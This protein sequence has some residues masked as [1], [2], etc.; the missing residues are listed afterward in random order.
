LLS[1]AIPFSRG[2]SVKSTKI[3]DYVQ[4]SGKIFA[5]SPVEIKRSIQ[6]MSIEKS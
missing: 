3:F 5:L 4:L 1:K 6:N 2:K